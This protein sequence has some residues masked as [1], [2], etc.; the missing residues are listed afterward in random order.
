MSL[1]LTYFKNVGVNL[2]NRI[3]NVNVNPTS[4]INNHVIQSIFIKST[5]T[6]EVRKI[7]K[8][9]KSSSPG[10]DD[11]SP[12]TIKTTSESLLTPLTHVLNLS[13][14]QGIF[15]NELKLTRIILCISLVTACC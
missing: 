12:D 4:Y 7:I 2:A 11:I 3:P 15:P 10:H 5:C 13:L 1:S 14:D 9:L 8:T 6:E